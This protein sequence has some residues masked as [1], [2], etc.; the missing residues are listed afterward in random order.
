MKVINII[1]TEKTGMP[2]KILIINETLKSFH[3]VIPRLK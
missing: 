1:R 3:L 2:T